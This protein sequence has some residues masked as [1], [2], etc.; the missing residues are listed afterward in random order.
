MPDLKT[1]VRKHM[2]ADKDGTVLSHLWQSLLRSLN[3]FVS[4]ILFHEFDACLRLCS[5]PLFDSKL[6]NLIRKKF[7]SATYV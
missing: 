6:K 5:I 4:S 1:L 3:Y 2:G 7:A